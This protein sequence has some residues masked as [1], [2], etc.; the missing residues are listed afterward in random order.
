MNYSLQ[1]EAG[2]TYE[3]AITNMSCLY[4]YRLGDV[5][6][7]TGFHKQCPKVEFLYR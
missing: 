7:V 6:K 4:R 3:L 1:V 5:V 2:Q